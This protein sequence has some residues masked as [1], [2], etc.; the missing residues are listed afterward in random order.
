MLFGPIEAED[1][2]ALLPE[3]AIFAGFVNRAERPDV[4]AVC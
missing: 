3:V 4:A 1:N 2:N